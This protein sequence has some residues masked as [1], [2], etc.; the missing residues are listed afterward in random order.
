[1]QEPS[2]V[3]TRIPYLV[4]M[5]RYQAKNRYVVLWGWGYFVERVLACKP[6]EDLLVVG[7]R[8]KE[9]GLKG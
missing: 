4:D 9:Q 6:W 5:G 3:K 1:M 8:E 7:S 2:P